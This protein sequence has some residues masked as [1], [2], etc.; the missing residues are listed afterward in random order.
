[1]QPLA[2]LYQQMAS[3]TNRAVE[4][5]ARRATILRVLCLLSGLFMLLTLLRVYRG[6]QATLGGPLAEVHRRIQRLSDG[7]FARIPRRPQTTATAFSA[8]CPAPGSA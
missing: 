2:D 6:L 8:R 3:R 4:E 1:M 5:A 7:D